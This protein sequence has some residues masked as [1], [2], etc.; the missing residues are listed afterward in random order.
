MDFKGVFLISDLDGTLIG[1]NYE[2][3]A[4]NLEAIQR[5]QKLGGHFAIATGRSIESAGAYAA[6]TFPN[7]PCVCVNGGL[8]YDYTAKKVVYEHPFEQ[9]SA[10][11]YM[12]KMIEHFPTLGAEYF[13]RHEIHVLRRN[14]LIQN[15]LT[16]EKARWLEPKLFDY[17]QPWYKAL[18]ADEPEV[19]QKVAAFTQTF[20]H[21]EVRFV[22][23]SEYF[24][25]MLPVK[26]S[27]GEALH[28]VAEQ[29]GFKQENVYAIGDYYNDLELLRAAGT[30]AV[31]ENA[32][33]DLQKMAD[34]VVGHCYQGA[35][36]D[37][38][39]WIAQKRTGDAL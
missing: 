17:S 5:F 26:S 14:S 36:A 34:V 35:V 2:V 7:G 16:N 20:E 23:S 24:C 37:F 6:L 19:I 38:I 9:K 30:A 13:C 29:F 33:E 10:E 27:K 22:L 3:P 31:P 18:F 11:I 21:P 4:R 8:A 12:R 28:A 15:H 1:E 25:E 39:D 32:P